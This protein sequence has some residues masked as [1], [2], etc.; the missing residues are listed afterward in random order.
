M[1]QRQQVAILRKGG[2]EFRILHL[3]PPA[4]PSFMPL[5]PR[6][7]EEDAASSFMPR[8]NHRQDIV[9]C[10]SDREVVAESLA[11]ASDLSKV[12]AHALVLMANHYL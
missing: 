8:G 2:L 1:E 4:L 12:K 11:A 5:A 3:L 10:H 6:I 7:E 9:H